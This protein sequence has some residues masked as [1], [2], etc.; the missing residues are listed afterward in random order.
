MRWLCILVLVVLSGC[1]QAAKREVR[2]YRLHGD[3]CQNLGYK[4]AGDEWAGC[5]ARL[6]RARAMRVES[7]E[8]ETATDPKKTMKCDFTVRPTVCK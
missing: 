2:S 8:A 6:E 5:T 7:F 1:N 4:T 3:A